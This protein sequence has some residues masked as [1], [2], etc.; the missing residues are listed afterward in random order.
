MIMNTTI[1]WKEAKYEFLKLIRTR[2][3][4]VSVLGMP[5][6]FYCFFALAMPSNETFHLPTYLLATYGTFGVM[7]ACLFGV[8]ANLAHERSLGWL[9]MKRVSPMSGSAY[10]FGK[11]AANLLFCVAVELSLLLT[12]LLFGH[13]KLTVWEAVRIT[14]VLVIG[15]IPFAALGV[16]LGYLVQ[17]SSAPATLNMINLPMAFCSGLWIP[18]MF[19][20][21][22]LQKVALFLPAYHLSKLALDMIGLDNAPA[23]A[24]HWE[25]LAA[26]TVIFI[27]LAFWAFARQGAVAEAR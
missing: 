23:M 3:Y 9:E 27:G 2:R 21:P 7:S 22:F 19:L 11:I 18:M 1:Y 13:V 8:G 25:A 17:A 6:M 10:L 20:P 5:L 24:Q 4:A 12:G 14:L 15:A 16:A 26:F